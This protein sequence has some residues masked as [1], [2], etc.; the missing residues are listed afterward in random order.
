MFLS[1]LP[2]AGRPIVHVLAVR[3]VL[4]ASPRARVAVLVARLALFASVVGVVGGSAEGDAYSFR[5]V[6]GVGG[7]PVYSNK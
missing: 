2:D 4:V 1:A 6:Q 7:H 5:S 3:A